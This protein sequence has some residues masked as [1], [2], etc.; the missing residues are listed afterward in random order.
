M[1]KIY[2]E[3][4]RPSYPH[5]DRKR[6]MPHESVKPVMTNSRIEAQGMIS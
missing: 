3:T 4:S 1:Y 2:S 6:P 5:V